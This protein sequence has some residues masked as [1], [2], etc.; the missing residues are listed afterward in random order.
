MSGHRTSGLEV[1]DATVRYGETVA[2][3]SREGRSSLDGLADVFGEL[4]F[5]IPCSG[6]QS[7]FDVVRV[8]GPLG[9]ALG[10]GER[11]STARK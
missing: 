5:G 6:V 4:G 3:L 7:G 10:A 1:R 9:S 8:S 2:L 11:S